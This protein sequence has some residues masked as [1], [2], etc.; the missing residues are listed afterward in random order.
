[1]RSLLPILLLAAT[2]VSASAQRFVKTFDNIAALLAANPNDVHTSAYVVG[3]TTP[4]DGGGGIY[5]WNSTS[6]AAT[7]SNLSILK[8]NNF[9]TGRWFRD[10][11]FLLT[12]L[13]PERVAVI[14]SDS[15]LTNGVVTIN[16]INTLI[17]ITSNIQDQINAITNVVASGTNNWINSGTTNSRL[18]GVA[19][20]WAAEVTNYITVGDLTKTGVIIRGNTNSSSN[21]GL[22][23]TIIPHNNTN[24]SNVVGVFGVNFGTPFSPLNPSHGA[25]GWIVES[26]YD[27]PTDT[28]NWVELYGEYVH[29][30]ATAPYPYWRNIM[31]VGSKGSGLPL[32]TFF[33][34]GLAGYY[35][36]INDGTGAIGSLER[37]MGRQRME[38]TEDVLHIMNS[39]ASYS[40]ALHPGGI[41]LWTG[42]NRDSFNGLEF[43]VSNSGA[44]SGAITQAT[45]DIGTGEVRY[46]IAGRAGSATFSDLA[47][48]GTLGTTILYSNLTV[49]GWINPFRVVS[50]N[51]LSTNAQVWLESTDAL[52][53]DVGG[54]IGF[55]ALYDGATA[56]P[57]AF[58]TGKRKDATFGSFRGVI[59]LDVMNEFGGLGRGLTITGDID[60]F[61]N[62]TSLF[63]GHVIIAGDGDLEVLG[64]IKAPL[65]IRGLFQPPEGA[66]LTIITTNSITNAIGG[67]I[68]FGSP[69][70]D[71]G[72]YTT[73]VFLTG[74]RYDFDPGSYRSIFQ[75][76]LRNTFGDL[77]PALTMLAPEND[78]TNVVSDFFGDL[79]VSRSIAVGEGSGIPGRIDITSTNG[80]WTQLITVDDD[81]KLA[82][83]FGTTNLFKFALDPGWTGTGTRAFFDDG[84]YKSVGSGTITGGANLGAGTVGPYA[85]TSGANLQFNSIAGGTAVTVSSNANI[86]TISST[87]EANTGSNLGA[88]TAGPFNSKSG[89]D[90]RFNSLAAGSGITVSSNANV[91]TIAATGGSGTITGGANLAS[92]VG[93]YNGV[94]GANLQFN[95]LLGAAG[96]TW[97]SNANALTATLAVTNHTTIALSNPTTTLSAGE[98]VNFFRMP[99]ASTLKSATALLLLTSSSGSVTMDLKTNGVS[100]LSAPVSI[101]AGNTNA[102]ATL[103]ATAILAGTI[104]SGDI[105]AAGTDAQGAQLQILYTTP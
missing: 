81:G 13:T 46:Y 6:T 40:D 73:N 28:N 91:I 70:D 99:F 26:N 47:S 34:A 49:N 37:T 36:G 98:N 42:N 94:S 86:I 71:A 62:A 84:T 30:N 74:N 44:G 14:G 38:L 19:R 67:S 90:L 35:W 53:A 41:S 100:I 66:M 20:P 25:V 92:G 17:G 63:N 50:T 39:G 78:D 65:Q 60:G 22:A 54:S 16:E 61:T 68:G 103:S 58:I 89:V 43:F 48:F 76:D 69:L 29:T 8:A 23:I 45:V 64:H 96:I 75:V 32:T 57:L 7:N 102:A 104:I 87:G 93:V 9:S 33:G 72:L 3:R 51:Q 85:S 27:S 82:G 4:N 24:D 1:M 18:I 59:G 83:Y 31:T 77:I 79:G 88:G 15:V 2:C 55:K 12:T 101:T 10:N 11:G 21:I 95:T 52:A 105:D 97:S 80:T 56:V 5:T